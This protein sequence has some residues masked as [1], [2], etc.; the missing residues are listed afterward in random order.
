[1]DRRE[2]PVGTG[3]RNNHQ[4]PHPYRGPQRPYEHRGPPPEVAHLEERMHALRE[5]QNREYEHSNK[6]ASEVTWCVSRIDELTKQNAELQTRLD[7][8]SEHLRPRSM[9]K[10]D[11]HERARSDD[12]KDEYD[13]YDD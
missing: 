6:L 13:G 2:R 1:M 4:A 3:W 7:I 9:D 10:V 5:F 12:G 8:L 11:R